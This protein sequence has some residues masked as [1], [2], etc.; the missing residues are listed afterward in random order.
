MAED[1]GAAMYWVIG[2]IAVVA[3]AGLAMLMR[4]VARAGGPRTVLWLAL[5][6]IGVGIASVLGQIAQIYFRLPLG[7]IVVLV[8]AA[9]VLIALFLQAARDVSWKPLPVFG[10]VG[11]MLGALILTMLLLIALP[12]G[13]FFTPLFE[14]RAQQIG[15]AAGFEVLVPAT[16]ELDTDEGMPVSVIGDAEGIEIGYDWLTLVERPAD[17]PLGYADLRNLVPPGSDPLGFE[18]EDAGRRGPGV[19]EDAEYVELE[20][21]GRP[22]LGVAYAAVTEEKVVAGT[23]PDPLNVLIFERDGVLVRLLSQGGMDYQPDGSYT[24]RAALTFDELVE[25]AESLTPLEAR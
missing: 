1:E 25:L 16:L 22:A 23:I 12:S 8:L 5:L 19:P 18:G 7:W 14:I 13:R 10:V 6:A 2:G 17:A 24:Q 3:I 11:V 21:D 4:A 15:E 20:V 9:I